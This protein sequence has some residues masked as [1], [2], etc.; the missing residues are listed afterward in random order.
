MRTSIGTAAAA[1][2]AC[3]LL[4]AACTGGGA[5]KP[6][7][8]P[9]VTLGGIK[10][11]SYSGCDDMLEGLRGAAAKNVG[12][13]GFG[14]N[15]IM[16]ATGEVTASRD[17]KAAPAYSTTNVHE[18]GVD[19]P[20]MVKTDGERIISYAAGV[21]R[22]VDV[23]TRKETGTLRLVPEEQRWAPGELLVHGDRALVI[24][25]AGDVV[26]FGA[27][28]KRAAVSGPR[29]VLVD[30]KDMKPL[31]TITPKGSHVDARM[32][33]S[34]VRL[35]VR[36][37]PDI[38]FPESRPNQSEDDLTRRNQDIVRKAPIDAWLPT[39][40]VSAAG[41]PART[42]KLKCE[43]VSHPD[44]YTGTSLLSVHT[45]DLEAGLA[46]GDPIAVAADGDT[47]YATPTSLYVTSNPRYWWP[48]PIDARPIE[49]TPPVEATPAPATPA[50]VSPGA[51]PAD[52]PTVVAPRDPVTSPPAEKV[53][54]SADP[55]MPTLLPEPTPSPSAPESPTATPTAVTPSPDKSGSPEDEAPP[56]RTEVHRFDISGAGAPR[57]VASGA[58][59]GRL[60]N[61]YSLSDFDGHL[62]VATTIDAPM[63]GANASAA[64]SGVY[65]LKADTLAQV[66]QVTGLGKGERIYS[67]R[68]IGPVGY[69]VTFKQVDPLYTL[70]LRDPARPAVRGELKI[71][72]YSAYLHPAGDG[73]LL[74]IGQEASTQ[75]RTL[76]MQ[77][78][79]FDVGDPAAPKRLSR[80]HQ[81]ESA[82]E[83]E[84][85]PHA[86]LYWPES[87]LA[88]LPVSSWGGSE[89]GESDMAAMVLKVGDDAITQAG[90]V[91]HPKPAKS[92]DPVQFDA[93]I[94]R[95]LII[96]DTLWTLSGAGLK[97]S[98]ATSLADQAWIPF[99]V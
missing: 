58:V 87:G 80:F 57:Y 60:L 33:G 11:V 6:S 15:M 2:L 25:S 39:Y 30:L 41:Q 46:S 14:G 96:G 50:P 79:L 89:A 51:A 68:F 18:A 81:K 44:D 16:F 64:S 94:Q 75:G 49:D 4:T 91:R 8:A 24:F 72:G 48:R 35:V 43:Q 7:A 31:G 86:F 36:S 32:T 83:A 85:D 12:P 9:P 98:D 65:V 63:G 88:V 90:L 61:Q 47:V 74:G 71:T 53:E 29:Y 99:R 23:A 19:E 45:I 22:V 28:A 54:P 26:P 73:R 3:G 77:V 21:L 78:S 59:P 52:S 55:S 17:A 10:L 56:D 69:V 20:D 95:C 62:R 27:T 38:T 66:G 70:D 5:A 42:E 1:A 97:A 34:T 37:Q 76:G 84:W 93:R 67:V 13:W 40:E 82:S 92:Q